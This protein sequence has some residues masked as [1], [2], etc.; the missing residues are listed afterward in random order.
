[1]AA[2]ELNLKAMGFEVLRSTVDT[3]API[4]ANAAVLAAEIRRWAAANAAN[5][6]HAAGAASATATATAAPRPGRRLALYCHSKGACD[7]VA[8]LSHFPSTQR[9]LACVV[10]MQGPHGGSCV[11]NDISVT[12]VQKSIAQ[13]RE[14]RRAH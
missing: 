3:G 10:S 13:V 9:H 8:A 7:A 6:V 4:A 12:T 14:K 1:M 11:V 5:A 2:L